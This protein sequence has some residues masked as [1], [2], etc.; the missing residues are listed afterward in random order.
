VSQLVK[1]E[2]PITITL[3]TLC[4][5]TSRLYPPYMHLSI[6]PGLKPYVCKVPGCEA[7]DSQSFNLQ[8]HVETTHDTKE[9]PC[10]AA[11]CDKTYHSRDSLRAHVASKHSGV[12]T[13]P[14]PNCR[15]GEHA[16]RSQVLKC[17]STLHC[18][19]AGQQLTDCCTSSLFASAWPV[20]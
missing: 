14:C 10:E 1:P 15:R 5:C 13:L 2:L 4:I 7:A 17:V 19:E 11:G 20:A 6:L 8:Q 12:G 16:S 9:F 3:L 18:L